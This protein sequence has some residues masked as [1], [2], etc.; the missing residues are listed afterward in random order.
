MFPER[1]YLPS[2]IPGRDKE[3]REILCR[4]LL[5]AGVCAEIL[6]EV[7]PLSRQSKSSFVSF[8]SSLRSQI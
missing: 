3:I 8:C 6:L 5:A 1:Q 2:G 4:I 7:V